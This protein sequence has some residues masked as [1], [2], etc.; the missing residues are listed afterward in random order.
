MLKFIND[1]RGG[2]LVKAEIVLVWWQVKL[3]RVLSEYF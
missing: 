2:T 1:K 3:S